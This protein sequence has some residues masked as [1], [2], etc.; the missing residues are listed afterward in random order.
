MNVSITFYSVEINL[1]FQI[2]ITKLQIKTI[3]ATWD[4]P[5]ISIHK[6]VKI[7]TTLNN[8]C[9]ISRVIKHLPLAHFNL[10]SIYLFKPSF[11]HIHTTRRLDWDYCIKRNAI[12]NHGM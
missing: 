3:F 9:N 11:S 6:A 12:Y 10:F 7:L 8:D 5:E 1:Q 2:V 4:F